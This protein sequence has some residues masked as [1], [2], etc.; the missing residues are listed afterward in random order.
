MNSTQR[1]FKAILPRK[2]AE[3]ME[4]ESRSWFLRCEECGAER[5]VWD[6]GGIRNDE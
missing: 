5:S 3:D 1:F 4:A 6:A 2:L